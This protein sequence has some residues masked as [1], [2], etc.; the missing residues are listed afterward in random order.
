M[1]TLGAS[2]G[3]GSISKKLIKSVNKLGH[4]QMRFSASNCKNLLLTVSSR[5]KFFILIF[6]SKP[7]CVNES[8]SSASSCITKSGS[9][10]AVFKVGTERKAETI[11]LYSE[12]IL[13]RQCFYLVMDRMQL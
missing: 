7:K 11:K 6:P 9:T 13:E 10:P 2:N 3:V 8:L 4:D 1:A 5:S 12:W